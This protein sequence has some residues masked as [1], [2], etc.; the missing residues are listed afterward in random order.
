MLA[1]PLQRKEKYN[2]KMTVAVKNITKYYGKQCV[3]DSVSFTLDAGEITGLLGPNGAG[4]TTTMNIIAG[5]L[6]HWE[7]DVSIYGK[8]L[9][10]HS[11]KLRKTIGYLP[12]HNPLDE[13]LYVKEFLQYV[14]GLY[15]PRKEVSQ[16]V[17]E[18]VD[19]VGL[20]SEQHKKIAQLSKG[21]KQRVG[22][23]Q[24]L[25]HRPRLL[26]L[27]E[28][29]TGLD[30]NQLQEI[31]NLIREISHDKTVLLSTH[32]MQEVEA[33]CNRTLIINNGVLVN[34]SRCTQ[35]ISQQTVRVCFSEPLQSLS[36]PFPSETQQIDDS[37]FLVKSS[38]AED[39]CPLI[40]D[41][42]KEKDL[43]LTHL[44]KEKEGIEDFF[45]TLVKK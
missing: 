9:R 44:S 20:G 42:A 25:V 22:L 1:F 38:L 30:P 5:Y 13:Q 36:L 4:K 28:P 31:R 32:I 16:A 6:Q 33:L 3:L 27:D 19:Q 8:N 43:R 7:G 18:V 23:A 39:I 26:I 34:D 17:K 15:L 21:Y 12:E 10:K 45:A 41:F 40:F 2:F 14:A 29:T 35:K 24:A 37:S 11:L